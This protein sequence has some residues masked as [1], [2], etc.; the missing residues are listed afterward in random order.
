MAARK[1]MA[2]V[3]PGTLCLE[4]V[5]ISSP[6]VASIARLKVSPL[7]SGRLAVSKTCFGQKKEEN[8]S[9]NLCSFMARIIKEL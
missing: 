8:Q 7:D 6:D 3:V 5:T 1:I 4:S 9:S 2:T